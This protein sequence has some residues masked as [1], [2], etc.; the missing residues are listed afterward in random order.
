[1]G[2]W[3]DMAAPSAN[4]DHHGSRL[5]ERSRGAGQFHQREQARGPHP[6]Q[7]GAAVAPGEALAAVH[8]ALDVGAGFNLLKGKDCTYTQDW[9]SVTGPRAVVNGTV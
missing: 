9:L 5:P 1:M 7:H 4:V 8:R 3:V 2:R 6:P